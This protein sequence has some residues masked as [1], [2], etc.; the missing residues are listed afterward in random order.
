MT[1]DEALAAA[2]ALLERDGA[3]PLLRVPELEMASAPGVRVFVAARHAPITAILCD[4]GHFSL[5]HYDALLAQV[6]G[7]TRY[8]VG[9]NDDNRKL[10]L[11]LLRAA[12]R[13]VDSVRQP[14]AAP[15]GDGQPNLAPG[16]R[17]FIAT[18]AREE[19]EAILTIL[20]AR[21]AA[22][23]PINFVRDYAFLLAYR[24]A[25]RVVGVP[26]PD[27]PRLLVRLLILLRNLTCPA[28]RVRLQGEAGTA[29]TM[30]SLLL[31]LFGHV[32][33]TVVQSSAFLRWLT[34]RT[35][36]RALAAFDLALAMPGLAPADSLLAGLDAVRGDFPAVSDADYRVQARS[37]LFELAG[38][39]VLIVGKSLAE[40]AGYATSPAGH[41]AGL[42]WD[43]LIARLAVDDPLR[44]QH[45]AVVN[46]ALRLGSTS[47]L[48][49]TVRE[50]CSWQGVDL[51]KG[52]R[53]LLLIDKGSR[54]PAA[55]ASPE[56]FAPATDRPYIT[57][58]P[59]QGPHVCY[60]RAIAW[61]ILREGLLATR[62]RIVPVP[63]A[64]MTSF[65][66]LPDTLPFTAA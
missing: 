31:P 17:D 51:G 6:A 1:K 30:L 41:A 12:Q 21:N 14:P 32:F 9:E 59:L 56:R 19:A 53:V 43:G 50:A 36:A 25:R 23:V 15:A 10:R 45:D 8:L 62:D 4:E 49:R 52:D 58:G 54:D 55:F 38:A 16:Y 46:E 2:V 64:A 48:V 28:P 35:S 65:A 33:G 29:T 26:A 20:R 22:G 7:P 57:S 3:P 37:V 39:L 11:A 47:Q 27:S 5:H 60:G 61:T 18:I 13:H 40:I 42:D 63:A 24:M 66:G 34:T 44:H